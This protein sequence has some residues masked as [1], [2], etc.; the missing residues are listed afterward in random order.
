MSAMV[1]SGLSAQT[2]RCSDLP[3]QADFRHMLLRTNHM[4]GLRARYTPL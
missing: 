1:N 2:F 4:V 3:S